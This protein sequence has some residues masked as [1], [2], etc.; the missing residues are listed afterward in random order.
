MAELTTIARPYAKAAFEYALGAQTVSEWASMLDFV[1]QAVSNNDVANIISNPSLSAEQK[2]E[3]I[4][5]I[6]EGQITDKVENFIKLLARNHRLEA[7]P[8]IK[9]RFDVLK[10]DYDKA[11]EVEVT[12]A[13]ALSDDQLQRLTEKLTAKLGRKVNIQTQVD[14]SMIGGLVIKAGDMV[15]DGSVRGKLNKL[16]ETLRAQ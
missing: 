2:G 3:V 13:A 9:I 12:S 16:S 6:S 4:L 10:A 7:L 11:V 8:A 15:I 1:A 5:K 14:S